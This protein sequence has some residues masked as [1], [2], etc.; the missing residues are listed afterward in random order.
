M[1][2]LVLLS[3]FALTIIIWRGIALRY[4]VIL[5]NEIGR[6][7]DALRPGASPEAVI[8][9]VAKGD[10]PLAGV[11]RVLLEHRHWPITEAREATQSRARHEVA[12]MEKGLVFLEITTGVAPLFGLLGTLSGLIGVFANLGDSGDATLV[13][14]GIAEALNTTIMGL[15]VA[16]PSLIAFNYYMRKVEIMAI[17]M[18]AT[19]GDLTEKLYA[20]TPSSYRD[21]V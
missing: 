12:R 2:V 6:S 7:I 9:S 10:S 1:F 13:A 4:S 16:A 20:S 5:P 21:K 14:R 8:R 17:E 11:T 15:A 18:E 3:V 19:V